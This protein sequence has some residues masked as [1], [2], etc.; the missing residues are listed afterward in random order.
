MSQGD[1]INMD[2]TG[3]VV[4]VR[5]DPLSLEQRRTMYAWGREKNGREVVCREEESYRG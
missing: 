1:G 2:L 3:G 4:R 5:K